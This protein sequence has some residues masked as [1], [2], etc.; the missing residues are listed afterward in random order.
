MLY[1]VLAFQELLFSHSEQYALH[2]G[3][4]KMQQTN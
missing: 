4:V 1:L 2:R 3:L